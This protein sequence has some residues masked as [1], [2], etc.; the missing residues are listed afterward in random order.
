MRRFA[1]LAAKIT[2]LVAVCAMMIAFIEIALRLVRIATPSWYHMDN[3][4]GY[5]LRPHAE[6]WHRDEGMNFVRISSEGLHDDEH[7]LQKPAGTLRIAVLGDSFTEAFQVSL[8][9][10]F[11]SVMRQEIA[12]C[13]GDFSIESINFGVGGY[14]TAQE[15]LMLRNR[16]WLYD[17]DIVLLAFFAGNDIRNNSSTL[18][19]D[20]LRPYFTVRGTTLTEDLSFLR[21]P[22]FIR[23]SS[24]L[25]T[26]WA[27]VVNH[28]RFLQG[29]SLLWHTA[30]GFVRAR[31]EGKPIA[32][33]HDN[34]PAAQEG[35]SEAGIPEWSFLPPSDASTR[36]AWAVTEALILEMNQ[37]VS[38][39]GKRFAMIVFSSAISVH[40]DPS[41]R[42]QFASSIGA[43]SLTYTEDRIVRF[44]KDHG[45]PALPLTKPLLP[46][47]EQ[48]KQFL[49][50]FNGT[51][52]G[53]WNTL[54]HRI[55][56]ELTGRFLCEEVLA[57]NNKLRNGVSP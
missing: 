6:G 1:P 38:A 26:A 34:T 14:G 36:D 17:P 3:V 43:P 52:K 10:A 53:H 19:G 55:V 42:A 51:G 25:R 35:W 9:E 33:K 57:T 27:S 15:L 31:F 49:H 4:M 24:V 11:W 46:Y 48:S 20:L 56:G 30:E 37:E 5:A 54:G 50:S 8:P 41:V 22:T 32:F 2:L 44:A 45:I 29:V 47:A 40:P 21:D 18:E 39:H 7:S 23:Q 12:M 13:E 16:V 28:S